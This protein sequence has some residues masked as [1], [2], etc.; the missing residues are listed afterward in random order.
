MDHRGTSH[1]DGAVVA[2]DDDL[3]P[4]GRQGLENLEQLRVRE[5][6]R[7]KRAERPLVR[8]QLLEDL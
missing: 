5:P 2:R 8:R 1:E 4:E 3:H 7:E 6:R